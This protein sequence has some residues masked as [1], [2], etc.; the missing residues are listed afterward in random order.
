MAGQIE[1]G[2]AVV[3]VTAD[4]SR[5]AAGLAQAQKQLQTFA[6]GAAKF[7]GGALAGA[8]GVLAPLAAA[9]KH[10]AD[11]GSALDDM[12]QRTGASV[13]ALS[14]LGYAAQ[15]SGASIDDI[16][17]G[18]RTMQKGLAAG[19]D[20][21]SSLGLNM[22]KLK[23]IH[24][25]DQFKTIAEAISKI[26]DPG[27]RAAKAM[28]IFG[29][30]GATL[31]PL[32]SGGA[33]GIEKLIAEA[34]SLGVIMSGE[35]AN[36][37]AVL[38]DSIDKVSLAAGSVVNTIGA[39]LAPA[40]TAVF[41]VVT[42]GITVLRDWIE[43]NKGIVLAIAGVA[44]VVGILG[45]VLVTGAGLAMGL[46]VAIG[47]VG[48]VASAVAS[49]LSI[50]AG[51]IGGVL[52]SGP[53]LVILAL[54]ALAGYL[55]YVSGA[56]GQAMDWLSG[57]FKM[58]SDIAGPVFK[59]IQDAMAGGDF[60]LAATILWEGIQLAWV[61]GTAD[62]SS[63]FTEAFNGMMNMLDGWIATFRSKWND[64][65]GWI[66]DGMLDLMGTFDSSFDSETA[67]KFRQQETKRQNQGFADGVK[68]RAADRDAA[69]QAA[70]QATKDRIAALEGKLADSLAKAVTVAQEAD[71]KNLEIAKYNVPDQ[72]EFTK[73]A[74]TEFKAKGVENL[75][76]SSGFAA[77]LQSMSG[78]GGG[79]SLDQQMYNESKVQS[80]LLGKILDKLTKDAIE[81]KEKVFT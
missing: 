7:G 9:V 20:S 60:T 68:G 40:F 2:K 36:S 16:E 26:E 33:V 23:S 67:K 50:L 3:R 48:A 6:A 42:Y 19:D 70:E 29:K 10:F 78:G 14:A 13:E 34:D 73:D 56:G 25:D 24:P 11:A 59:G 65:S 64:V 8:A 44:A 35:A 27:E 58:L 46:S 18:I 76:T 51:V 52:A 31:T 37:A 30:S 54:T 22:E 74:A 66:A 75:G 1:A 17:K 71:Q 53:L 21:F 55:T 15:M 39:Q 4:R 49:A 45:T 61:K 77:M 38:G 57:K 69:A 62:I 80:K 12:S 43:A 28:E 63:T 41:A 81:A 79:V 72:S 5:L 47:A 32:L